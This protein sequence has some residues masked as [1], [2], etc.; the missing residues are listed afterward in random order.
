MSLSQALAGDRFV[1][2]GEL[3]PPKGIALEAL[4]QTADLLAPMV[5]A[6]NLTDSHGARMSTCALAV[7]R[8][9]L[10]RGI[11]PIV[12]MTSRDRNRIALQSD[13]LGAAALGIR[14]VVIMGGDPPVN[15]DHPDA[16]PVFDLFAA[17][18]L[19]AARA[20]ERGE[21][22]AGN[23]LIGPPPVFCAGAVVNPGA[24]D[25]DEEIRRMEQKLEAGAAFF[26]TQAVYE[27]AAF[28][29]FARRVESFR[30]PVLAGIILLKSERMATWMNEKVPGIHVPQPL[31]AR[32]AAATDP[33]VECVD[34]ALETLTAIRGMCRGAHL[35]A[36]G[37]ETLLP[38]LVARLGVR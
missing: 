7:A 25:L 34:I 15:G 16:R 26:Q 33:H 6:I 20:L 3:T 21:D 10:E 4:F 30:V 36:L 1:V 11:E 5:D 18:L 35:M 2:T 14:N 17:D 32:I 9:L 8:L 28:E 38:S 24:V 12:Q 29:R 19:R 27:A 23:A 22:L 13:L 37:W 31:V